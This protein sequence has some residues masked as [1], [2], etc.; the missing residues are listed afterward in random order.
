MD[1]GGG[2]YSLDVTDFGVGDGLAIY[3]PSQTEIQ[4]VFN[5][6]N[7]NDAGV[8]VSAINEVT[9]ERVVTTVGNCISIV[10]SSSL[11]VGEQGTCG[12]CAIIVEGKL[13]ARIALHSSIFS[14]EDC[15]ALPL[16]LSAYRE[17]EQVQPISIVS[18][19]A[20]WSLY[21]P[22]EATR[23]VGFNL[24]TAIGYHEDSSDVKP[25]SADGGEFGIEFT[26]PPTATSIIIFNGYFWLAL[27]GRSLG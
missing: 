4:V 12:V 15:F 25:L 11:L 14:V 24:P 21:S 20:G 27:D 16:P 10:D 18:N 26:T 9:H 17:G 23:V 2:D 5:A 7:V 8:A 22:D 3:V 19:F 1:L 13:Y 6:G